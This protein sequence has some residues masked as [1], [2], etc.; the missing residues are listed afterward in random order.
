MDIYSFRV[1]P[2]AASSQKRP[3]HQLT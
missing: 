2:I 1:A 3:G